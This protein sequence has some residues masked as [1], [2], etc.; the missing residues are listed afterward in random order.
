ML[1]GKAFLA[2]TQLAIPESV[3]MARKEERFSPLS[4]EINSPLMSLM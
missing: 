2:K 4:P 3:Q 1:L